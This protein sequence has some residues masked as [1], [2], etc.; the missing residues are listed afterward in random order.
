MHMQSKHNPPT[1]LFEFPN[2]GASKSFFDRCIS[3]SNVKLVQHPYTKDGKGAKDEKRVLVTCLGSLILDLKLQEILTIE[4]E[5][6]GGNFLPRTTVV[7][8]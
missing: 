3:D 5:R 7:L 1:L 6:L 2:R 8:A 4:A